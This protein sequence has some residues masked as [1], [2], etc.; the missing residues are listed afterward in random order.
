[1]PQLPVTTVVTPWLSFGVMAALSI[2]AASSW[3]C[4]SMNPGASDRPEASTISSASMARSAP[5][6]AITPEVIATSA[7]TG[8]APV[9]S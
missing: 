3:V 1:M 6:A 2:T 4:T 9:P 5:T 7:R 8:A